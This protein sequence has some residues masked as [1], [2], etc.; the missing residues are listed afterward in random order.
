MN[1]KNTVLF[2]LTVSIFIAVSCTK[3][4][5]EKPN[6]IIILADDMGYGDV[7]AFNPESEIPTPN[8]NKF[9]EEGVMFTDA[10]TPSSVCTPTR[11]GLLTGR[12]CWRSALKNGVLRGYDSPLIEEDRTT[13]AGYLKEKGYRT[14]IVGKWHLGLGFQSEA[15]GKNDSEKKFDLTKKLYS[16]P[17]TYGFDY[18][19]VLPASLDF[20][21]YVFVRDFNVVDTGL[22]FV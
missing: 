14:G 9:S 19:F 13:I 12:Y 7:Q 22:D 17:N 4:K 1:L 6:I 8:L 10:H 20:E 15:D 11:Y 5:N 3:A 16:S 18:S 2:Y 21:P